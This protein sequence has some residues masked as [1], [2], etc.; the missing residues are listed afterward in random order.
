MQQENMHS[1]KDKTLNEGNEEVQSHKVNVT[2]R[3]Q[4]QEFLEL[5]VPFFFRYWY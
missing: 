1:E 4:E 3:K 5:Q 2:Q